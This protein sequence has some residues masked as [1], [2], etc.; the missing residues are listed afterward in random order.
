MAAVPALPVEA[1]YI[2]AKRN[3]GKI[4]V[5][6]QNYQYNKV[7]VDGRRVF[8]VCS[9]KKE[10]GCKVTA[11]VLKEEGKPDRI[12][13]IT[14]EHGHD[15][16]LLKILA[17]ES[18]NTAVEEASRNIVSPRSVMTN[19]TTSLQNAGASKHAVNFLPTQKA[20]A[21]RVNRARANLQNAPPVPKTW[22]E[23]VVPES[24]QN[25]ATEERFLIMEERVAEGREEKII[26]FASPDGIQIMKDAVKWAADGTFEIAENTLF[27]QVFIIISTTP[28]NVHVPTCWF[29]LPNKEAITY[30][31]VFSFLKDELD[32][33]A[34]QRFYCDFERGI[35]TSFKAVYTN[36]RVLCCDT[37]FKRAIRSNL[38]KFHLQSAYNKRPQLQTFVRHLWALTLVPIT[39]ILDTFTKLS[40]TGWPELG[41]DGEDE[42]LEEFASYFE[43]TWVGGFNRRTK[44]RQ[45]PR[46]PHELWN[47]NEAILNDEDLTTNSSEGYNLQVKLALPKG[48]RVWTVIKSFMREESLVALKL[49]D[50]AI[51]TS[52]AA[53]SNTSPAASG[54]TSPPGTARANARAQKKAELKQLVANYGNLSR[55]KFMDYAVAYYNNSLDFTE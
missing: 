22:A 52:P 33:S 49:R 42:D 32:I 8:W 15:T 16:D 25:T 10:L 50:A 31:K 46:F 38:Q 48:A 26:G 51:A 3:G 53:S 12:T 21:K 20:I 2:D 37:H 14:G 54:S 55:D 30:K 11:S 5:D 1:K 4:L 29:L 34:P 36:C 28:H 13:K 27:S 23:M 45:N 18:L 7:K 39:D 19:I 44:Q 40:E 9:K 41:D 35:I 6:D 47:K 43:T 17:S 24:L